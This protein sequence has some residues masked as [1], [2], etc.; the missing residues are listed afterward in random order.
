MDETTIDV[1]GMSCD[2]CEANVETAL[3]SLSG[4]SAATADHDAGT[5]RVTHDESAVDAEALDGAIDDA[6]YEVA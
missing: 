3:E 2:G 4:V 6:G 1:R 5:V